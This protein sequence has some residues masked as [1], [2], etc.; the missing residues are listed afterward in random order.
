MAHAGG[1]FGGHSGGFGGH[2]GGFGGF[3]GFH[4]GGRRSDVRLKENIVALGRLDNGIALYRF[5]YKGDDRTIYVG[6]LAQEVQHVVPS[7][8]SRDRDGYLRVDYDKLGIEFT[9]WDTWQ[10]RYRL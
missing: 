1:G 2:G 3:G 10:A 8:V 7:A 5:R 6:V 9:T 4:G